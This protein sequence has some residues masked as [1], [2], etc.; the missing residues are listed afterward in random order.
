M[1]KLITSILFLAVMFSFSPIVVANSGPTYW[2]G[3]PAS[4]I[5]AISKNSPI[6][7]KNEDLIFDFSEDEES[8]YTTRGRVT[9]TYKMANPTNETLLVQMAFP[10]VEKLN[11]LTR[12][13]VVITAD[14]NVL[15]YEVYIGDAVESYGSPWQEDKETSFDFD[16]IV[17]SITQEEYETKSFAE[18]EKGKLYLINV[19]PTTEQRINLAVDFDFNS[20]KTKVITNGFN[21]YERGHEKTKIAAW[22]DEPEV[23]E[24]F[25]LGTDI[26]FKINGF[27]DGNLSEETKFFT[28][29]ISTQEVEMKPYL[30]EYITTNTNAINENLGYCSFPEL[31]EQAHYQRILTL[32]YDVKFPP[33]SEKEISVSYMTTGTMDK[34]KTVKP[35][36]SFNYILNPAKN[37]AAFNNLNIK[38]ITPKQAP[39]LLRSSIELVKEADRM[40]TITLA[41]LPEDDLTFT[42]YEDE[43]I[44]V[45]DKVIGKFQNN[46]GYITLIIIVA[47][48]LII[49]KI[50]Q[51]DGRKSL[52]S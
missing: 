45:L 37:W 8:D 7:V 28:Y 5:M 2:Q 15:P 4:E 32:V 1:K 46:Y 27:T 39:Y 10:F 26:D 19:K 12:E 14:D 43:Q 31:L 42:L 33:N 47:I 25:V 3:Y 6:T 34:T 48:G 44:T 50:R 16:S 13:D 9:A 20:E 49:L 52:S 51:D 18:N 35:L 29:Q 21:R 23:L 17:H 24:I 30:L 38:I 40:Y 11:G 36:Y 22:C 41:E